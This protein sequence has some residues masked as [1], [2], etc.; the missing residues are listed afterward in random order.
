MQSGHILI[1]VDASSGLTFGQ[2][3]EAD[4]TCKALNKVTVV[5]QQGLYDMNSFAPQTQKISAGDWWVNRDG[6]IV[7][8]NHVVGGQVIAAVPA[9]GG[10]IQLE[11]FY[12][13]G[14][15]SE[16]V[17]TERDL[18]CRAGAGDWQ[19]GDRVSLCR[20]NGVFL[21][22]VPVMEGCHVGA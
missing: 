10:G 16:S 19:I 6:V 20:V 17:E 3:Y 22:F 13:S 7:L 18:I 15:F 21:K 12:D 2:R 4:T 1:C 14:R 8:V 11:L 9:D 5:G